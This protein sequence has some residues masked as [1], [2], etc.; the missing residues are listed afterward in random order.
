MTVTFHVLKSLCLFQVSKMCVSE[1][2][3]AMHQR[4]SDVRLMPH[5]QMSCISDLTIIC[6]DKVEP[7]EVRYWFSLVY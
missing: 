4:A 7:G 2:M 6:Q 5:I 3:R 1:V